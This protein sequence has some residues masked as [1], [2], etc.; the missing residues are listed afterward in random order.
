M[1]TGL[2]PASFCRL[3]SML[4]TQDAQVMPVI[5]T[6]HFCGAAAAEARGAFAER[7]RLRLSGGPPAWGATC[8]TDTGAPAEV[9]AVGFATLCCPTG[10][11][12]QCAGMKC[13]KSFKSEQIVGVFF[14]AGGSRL[15]TL[16]PGEATWV[17][18]SPPSVPAH[19]HRERHTGTDTRTMPPRLQRNGL[20]R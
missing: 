20:A 17:S 9:C 14:T 5:C 3:L 1:G 18:V 11:P 2:L 7:P 12:E 15:A 13:Q 8:C 19:N 10:S 4:D 16:T 6:K